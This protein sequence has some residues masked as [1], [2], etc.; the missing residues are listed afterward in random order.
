MHEPYLGAPVLR[1]L[2]YI[3]SLLGKIFLLFVASMLAYWLV[4]EAFNYEIY[5]AKLILFLLAS[6]VIGYMLRLA[7]DH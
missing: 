4:F 2:R 6:F 3:F 1:A 7:V 5:T